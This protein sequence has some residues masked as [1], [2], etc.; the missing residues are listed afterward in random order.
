[1]T[2]KGTATIETERLILRH[3][4][5]QDAEAA[6]ANWCSDP[7]VTEFLT[8]PPHANVQATR[9]V[10]ESWAASGEK[11]NFYQWAIVLKEIG[12]P[13]GSISVVGSDENVGQLE[14]GYC[15]GSK[16]WHRGITSEAFAAVIAFLFDEVGADRIQARHA[17]ENPR[18]GSVMKKC[19]LVYEGTLRQ[20]GRCNRG[21]TDL[22][23]YSILRGEY[24]AKKHRS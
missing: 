20:A 24:E 5:P 12:Q 15:I 14:I 22:C 21:I 6:F 18:S 9:G 4:S 17:V 19:G 3:F 8:W 7:A 16:W 11:P 23:I 2:H 10:L 1:M 13:I